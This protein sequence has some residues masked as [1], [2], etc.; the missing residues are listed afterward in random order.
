M[1]SLNK[2]ILYGEIQS[3]VENK[4]AAD[5]QPITR[6]TLRAERPQR[7]DGLPS[8]EDLVP[9][10]AKGNLTEKCKGL[11][12]GSELFIEG[13]IITGRQELEGG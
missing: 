12:K 1:S 3:D 2:I 13:R 11:S 6:F 8:G 9:V 10:F 7:S 4:E 5:S